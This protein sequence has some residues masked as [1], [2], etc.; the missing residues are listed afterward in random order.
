MTACIIPFPRTRN[1][2]FIIKHAIRMAN[3]PQKTAEKHLAYQLKVQA[4]TMARRGIPFTTIDNE[5]CTLENAIRA[6]LWHV[7]LSR[8]GAA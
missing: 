2:P 3:L 5:I 4:Q 6:E 8:G 1:R 7:V